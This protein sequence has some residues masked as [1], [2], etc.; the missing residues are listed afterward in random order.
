MLARQRSE[1]LRF[2]AT[3]H[4]RFIVR[5]IPLSTEVAGA[6]TKE[7]D[8][9]AIFRLPAQFSINQ[10]ILRDNYRALMKELHP[11]KQKQQQHMSNTTAE[12]DPSVITHAYVTLKRP[13]SRAM[14]LMELLGHEITEDTP[15]DLLPNGFLME[16]MERREELEEVFSSLSADDQQQKLRQM[17]EE[18]SGRIEATGEELQDALDKSDSLSAQRYT[19]MLQYYNRMLDAVV[20]KLDTFE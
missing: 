17:L 1:L 16:M 12:R 10:T 5:E 7:S 13:H 8:Y 15:P 11:D 14:Y 20:E 9:F 6:R 4:A 2:L 18:T 19:A 3:R